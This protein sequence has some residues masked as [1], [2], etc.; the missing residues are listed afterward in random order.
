M[1]IN[2]GPDRS[3]HLAPKGVSELLS[4]RIVDNNREIQSL[5][6]KEVISLE[7]I[8]EKKKERK[9]KDR[10]TGEEEREK[11]KII[12]SIERRG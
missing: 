7:R 2:L 9:K 4:E 11:E 8:T 6:K 12:D 10:Q 3:I 5:M 1:I